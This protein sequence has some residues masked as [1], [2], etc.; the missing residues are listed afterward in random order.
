MPVEGA[1]NYGP[2]GLFEFII[3]EQ[4][5]TDPRTQSSFLDCVC[6]LSQKTISIQSIKD[7]SLSE[8][9]FNSMWYTPKEEAQIWIALIFT[10]I[11][12]VILIVRVLYDAYIMPHNLCVYYMRQYYMRHNIICVKIICGINMTHVIARYS[13]LNPYESRILLFL[14]FL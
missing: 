12:F 11:L 5:L 10:S 6:K 1:Q 2:S 4:G 13:I 7:L 8:R 3:S 14:L 9:H